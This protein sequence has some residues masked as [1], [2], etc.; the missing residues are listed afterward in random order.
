MVYVLTSLRAG[1]RE[2]QTPQTGQRFA[3]ARGMGSLPMSGIRPPGIGAG[4][5]QDCRCGPRPASSPARGRAT[6]CSSD[7]SVVRSVRRV[8]VG[9]DPRV[10]LYPG[11]LAAFADPHDR[12]PRGVSLTSSVSEGRC[13]L[14]PEAPFGVQTDGVGEEARGPHP[15]VGTGCRQR[16]CRTR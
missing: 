4:L 6:R 7:N 12:A 5:T 3:R 10:V 2:M 14:D 8:M 1:S 11:A 15:P 16:R 9:E 13:C